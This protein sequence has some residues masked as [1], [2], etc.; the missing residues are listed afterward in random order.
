MVTSL[1]DYS[2]NIN[3]LSFKPNT[4]EL[5]Y[6]IQSTFAAIIKEKYNMTLYLK[7]IDFGNVRLAKNKITNIYIDTE[8]KEIY[9]NIDN[10]FE[11]LSLLNSKEIFEILKAISHIYLH[12]GNITNYDT[13]QYLDKDIQTHINHKHR[14]HKDITDE[15][16]YWQME[17]IGIMNTIETEIRTLAIELM[18]NNDYIIYV[19][20]NLIKSNTIK[21]IDGLN[22][23][24]K[25]LNID[26]ELLSY[27]LTNMNYKQTNIINLFTETN[28][29][30]IDNNEYVLN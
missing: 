9:L 30:D 8:T 14:N 13:Y 24:A 6:F 23:L 19:A 10:R 11:N 5:Y 26:V 3:G 25:I 1:K 21:L 22:Y 29:F 2:K 15:E 17:N 7:F 27:K 16:H 4:Y 20:N 12:T 18:V 28:I